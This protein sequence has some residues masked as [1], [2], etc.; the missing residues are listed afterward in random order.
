MKKNIYLLFLLMIYNSG[1]SQTLGVSGK[2]ITKNGNN[3]ILRGINYPFIDDG[4]INLASPASYQFYLNEAS[5]TGANTMRI[6]WYLPGTHWRDIQTPG[7]VQGYVNNGHLS[8]ILTYIESKNMIPILE[9]HNGTCGNDWNLFN[10]SIIPFWKSS[11]MLSIINAHQGSLIINLANEFGYVRWTGNTTAAMTT[12]KTNY[13]NAIT[14]LRDAGI[15]VPI[16]IDAPDCG[17]SSSE[18]V[19]MAQEIFNHD[20]L[21][22]IIFSA[23]AYW[24]DYAPTNTN[25]ETKLTEMT[26]SGL[27]WFFGEIAKNQDGNSCGS[28]DLSSY[29]PVLLT[30][31]CQRQI[32]W[33]AWTYDQD[34][35]AAR[36]MTTNGVFANLTSY[37]NDIV[38]NPNYGLKSTSGC[39][40]PS[41]GTLTSSEINAENGDKVYPT[42]FKD[43]FFVETNQEGSYNIFSI[44]GRQLSNGKLKKG[45]NMIVTKQLNSGAYIL[46]INKKSYKI[47]KF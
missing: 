24:S 36:E 39:G 38:N 26:N 30:K 14:Q 20:P 6:P 13:K 16:M 35:S 46:K 21:H 42:M 9:I 7:T 10:N 11:Q 15:N 37:G 19:S 43:R 45:K 4:N 40:V 47:I 17:T 44:D 34:C 27:C 41:S 29:Y 31:L 2:Y 5:K 22:K 32:G 28:I 12:F 33:A 3:I 23:H 25:I 8:N 18:L 1:F